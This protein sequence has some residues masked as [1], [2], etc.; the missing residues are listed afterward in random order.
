MKAPVNAVVKVHVSVL[1]FV[2]RY[3]ASIFA[4]FDRCSTYPY[5]AWHS[6]DL[7][8]K[9]MHARLPQ[10]NPQPELPIAMHSNHASQVALFA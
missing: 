10:R 5:I 1:C 4:M 7:S 9:P 6:F 2:N 8:S 3:L